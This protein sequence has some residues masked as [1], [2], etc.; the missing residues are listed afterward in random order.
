MNVCKAKPSFFA[1]C[2]G[3][4]GPHHMQRSSYVGPRDL[5]EEASGFDLEYS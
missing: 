1:T 3:G 5:F 4:G 2:N